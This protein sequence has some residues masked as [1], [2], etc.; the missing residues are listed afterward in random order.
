MTAKVFNEL[1]NAAMR[2]PR[3]VRL[4]YIDGGAAAPSR[5]ISMRHIPLPDDK[6]TFGQVTV[7][8]T[9]LQ[10]I[11]QADLSAEQIG[12]IEHKPITEYVVYEACL[13]REPRTWRIC[14]KLT[15]KADK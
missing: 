3:G 13:S 10:S 11:V 2:R 6:S 12:K 15:P 5:V 8:T 14:A 4:S 1:R 9:R 7:R